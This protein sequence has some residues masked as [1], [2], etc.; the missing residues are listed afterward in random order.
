M[1]LWST[2]FKRAARGDGALLTSGMTFPA[3]GAPSF[4]DLGDSL[5]VSTGEPLQLST[6]VG[7][8]KPTI[9]LLYSNC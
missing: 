2:L 4:P 9:A 8:G 6:V 1:G 3:E 7:A 5:L